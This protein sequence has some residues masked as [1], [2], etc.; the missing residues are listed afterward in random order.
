MDSIGSRQAQASGGPLP[1]RSVPVALARASAAQTNRPQDVHAEDNDGHVDDVPGRTLEVVPRAFR[2]LQQEQEAMRKHAVP[3]PMSPL[4]WP[5][6]LW[7]SFANY[8]DLSY[9]A[10]LVPV[11]L[12]FNSG[13]HHEIWLT[14]CDV[15]GA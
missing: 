6:F 9:T 5:A 1:R 4:S 11:S 7:M 15:I 13:S 3:L 8:T 2:R 10:F 12:A 14:I